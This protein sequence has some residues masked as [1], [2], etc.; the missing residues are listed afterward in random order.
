M[1]DFFNYTGGP[2]VNDQKI[3]NQKFALMG[4][5]ASIKKTEFI[6]VIS[7]K[8]L[9]KD[10]TS[11]DNNHRETFL[12]EIDS[13]ASKKSA[14]YACL[15]CKKIYLVENHQYQG[16]YKVYIFTSISI[17]IQTTIENSSTILKV[18]VKFRNIR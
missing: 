4:F 10:S 12:F 6:S 9:P 16:M 2:F 17:R 1:T 14:Y 5:L 18:F 3:E 15:F 7:A 11:S 13:R 8:F